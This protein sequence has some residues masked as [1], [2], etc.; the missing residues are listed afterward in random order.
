MLQAG[1]SGSGAIYVRSEGYGV[2]Q[3]V[4]AGKIIV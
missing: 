2:R 4:A 1:Q 3:K